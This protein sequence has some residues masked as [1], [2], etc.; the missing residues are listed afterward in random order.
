MAKN[1]NIPGRLHSV[2]I[3]GILAGAKEIFDD[4]QRLNQE[5]INTTTRTQ[6]ANILDDIS[7]LQEESSLV[8]RLATA[9]E[10][11]GEADLA[12]VILQTAAFN[13]R[14]EALN[15]SITALQGQ[16][17]G[18]SLVVLSED[19]YETLVTNEETDDN[20]LYYVTENEVE[21]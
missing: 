17:D 7:D 6:I 11:A 8:Q 20:T 16:L 18:L 5:T 1:I 10:E 3:N 2:A 13:T 4:N 12:Q 15:R 19:E 21:E 9:L 14:L